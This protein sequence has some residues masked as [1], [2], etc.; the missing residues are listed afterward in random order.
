MSKYYKYYSTERPIAPGTIPRGA[1]EVTNYDKKTYSPEI[2]RMAW[3][4]V[5]YP[6]PLESPD[7]WELVEA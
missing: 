3:G 4:Y 1:V 5:V 6:K 2:G 7:A